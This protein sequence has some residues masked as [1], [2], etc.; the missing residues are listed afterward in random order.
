MLRVQ[1]A[2]CQDG[3]GPLGFNWVT[4]GY[5]DCRQPSHPSRRS[6]NAHVSRRGVWSNRDCHVPSVWWEVPW[7]VASVLIQTVGAAYI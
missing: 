7:A 3:V 5:L 4:S 2:T 1:V 6:F